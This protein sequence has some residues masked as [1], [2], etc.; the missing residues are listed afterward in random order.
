MIAIRKVLVVDDDAAI[1]ETLSDVFTE[2]GFE[3]TGASNGREAL[4]RLRA[5]RHHLVVL[6]LMMP[7]MTG[8]EF[9]EEQLRDPSIASVPVIVVSAAHAPRPIAAAAF[10][11]KPFDLDTMLRLAD[12]LAS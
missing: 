6:D 4:E 1:R 8:W 2:E 7:V 12:R 11:S 3:V 5:C 10:L 9:R